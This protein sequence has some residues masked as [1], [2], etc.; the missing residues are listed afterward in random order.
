MA[1]VTRACIEKG[2]EFTYGVHP[3]FIQELLG[4][5]FCRVG[6]QKGEVIDI[7]KQL[8]KGVMGGRRAL[9]AKLDLL[10][11]AIGYGLTYRVVMVEGVRQLQFA[12]YKRNKVNG[13]GQLV[14]V[15]SLGKGGH[16]EH[17]DF[18]DHLL[19][20]NGDLDN[21]GVMDL[22]ETI[23]YSF[24]REYVEEIR[25]LLGELDVTTQLINSR[26]PVGFVHDTLPDQ[27]GYVGNHHFGVVYVVEAPH[28]ATFEM[29]EPQNDAVAWASIKDLEMHLKNGDQIDG[30][31]Y[32]PFEVWSKMI[33]QN[34]KPLEE[35]LLA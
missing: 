23:D 20:D 16:V 27:V 24:L 2:S 6:M 18:E 4:L 22:Y 1:V 30:P 11:Q 5:D 3:S 29:T 31:T 28:D 35:L 12:V 19:S 10:R 32:A 17:K 21:T 9:I 15:L 34:I 7:L 13:E 33:I 26:R 14:M 8:E 25:V